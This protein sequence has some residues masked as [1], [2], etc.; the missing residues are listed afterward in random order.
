MEINNG[1]LDSLAEGEVT[2]C[3]KVTAAAILHG[4]RVTSK[5]TKSSFLSDLDLSDAESFWSKMSD[6]EMTKTLKDSKCILRVKSHNL[7]TSMN[8]FGTAPHRCCLNMTTLGNFLVYLWSSLANFWQQK[9]QS[10]YF[11]VEV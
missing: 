3:H 8:L 7:V 11:D 2:N 1:S 4:F 10:S 6:L 5:Q 9:F